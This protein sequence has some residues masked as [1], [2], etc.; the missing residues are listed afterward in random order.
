MKNPDVPNTGRTTSISITPTRFR[1]TIGARYS[2]AMNPMTTLGSAAMIS[3]VGL[4]RARTVGWT[5]CD[6]Y[7]RAE[8]RDWNR[9]DAARTP[10][11]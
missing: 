2:P 3:T 4:M 7:K 9:E 11:P 1:S 10:C 8:H 5:N 6:V